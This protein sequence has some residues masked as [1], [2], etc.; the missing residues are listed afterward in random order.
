MNACRL[1]QMHSTDSLE[2]AL[3]LGNSHSSSDAGLDRTQISRLIAESEL[4]ISGIDSQMR[5]LECLRAK[6]HSTI[7]FLRRLRAPAP[8]DRLPAELVV[9]VFL[10]ST[11]KQFNERPMK[12]IRLSQVCH[13]WRQVAHSTSRFWTKCRI[14]IKENCPSEAYIAGIKMWLE[15]SSNLPLS[16]HF[17]SHSVGANLHLPI[18]A[19]ATMP[20]ISTRV[21]RLN[22]AGLASYAS[23]R[24]LFSHPL[25]SLESL[26]VSSN[27]REAVDPMAPKIDLSTIA[28]RLNSIILEENYPDVFTTPWSNLTYLHISDSPDNCL[29]VLLECK[30][31]KDASFDT[32]EWSD[33][34]AFDFPVI[35]LPH[36]RSLMFAVGYDFGEVVGDIDNFFQPLALPALTSLQFRLGEKPLSWPTA[37]FSLFQLRSPNIQNLD[38]SNSTI[39]P[40]GLISL[41]RS[42][43]AVKELTLNYCREC[44][45]ESFLRALEYHH[46]ADTDPLAPML[47][48]LTWDGFPR[49]FEETSFEAMIRSRW[50]PTGQP[51]PFAG[52]IPKI[53]RLMGTFIRCSD[54]WSGDFEARMK[55]CADDDIFI[56]S[57]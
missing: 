44:I 27:E 33:F 10:F 52:G 32:G 57:D 35:V 26:Q 34:G 39:S 25:D 47:E 51:P 21:K 20:S 24:L 8:I 13:Y 55:D 5:D 45:D 53:A 31:L 23:L 14:R 42:S 48:G 46:E 6:E 36:L 43:P 7:A 11:D 56:C 18:L 28:P 49:D 41:L 30:S 2:F 19:N 40:E 16:L 54:S 37:E 12:I 15:R 38:L 4:K 29:H 1:L 9:E 3:A 50:W 22:L 17:T